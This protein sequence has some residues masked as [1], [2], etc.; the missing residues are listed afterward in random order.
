M[1]IECAPSMW[2]LHVV[3]RPHLLPYSLRVVATT[4]SCA[5]VARALAPTTTGA[6]LSSRNSTTAMIKAMMDG[7][8]ML[9]PILHTPVELGHDQGPRWPSMGEL[10]FSPLA[11]AMARSTLQQDLDVQCCPNTTRPRVG[12]VVGIGKRKWR[13]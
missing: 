1:A 5:T 11:L 10:G 7:L 2:A 9:P 6:P 13:R 12:S 4:L 8:Y 3:P